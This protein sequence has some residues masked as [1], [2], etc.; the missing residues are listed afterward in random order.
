MTKFQF[1]S[2]IFTVV[3]ASHFHV[4]VGVFVDNF[5][6]FAGDRIVGVSGSSVSTVKS[7]VASGL[8][9]QEPSINLTFNVFGHSSREYVT[10]E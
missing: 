1:Q 7:I 5:A 9:F 3:Q 4:T 8:G 6:Q 10:N 2:L